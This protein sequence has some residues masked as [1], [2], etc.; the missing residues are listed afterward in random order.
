MVCSVA[1]QTSFLPNGVSQNFSG[2]LIPPSA[3]P[4]HLANLL[5]AIVSVHGI[6]APALLKTP[7]VV[8]KD[9]GNVRTEKIACGD[10]WR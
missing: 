2:F 6:T 9:E 10:G 5:N 4:I 8:L 3:H 7:T 1:F